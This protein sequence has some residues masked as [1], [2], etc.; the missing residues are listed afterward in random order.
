MTALPSR[1]TWHCAFCSIMVLTACIHGFVELAGGSPIHPASQPVFPQV[2][3][4]EST[5]P[6]PR[7]LKPP[8]GKQ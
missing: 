7:E 2:R 1:D 8:A 5:P 3:G 4:G 6:P